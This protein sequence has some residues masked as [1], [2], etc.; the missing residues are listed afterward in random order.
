LSLDGGQ[1]LVTIDHISTQ[2]RVEPDGSTQH[3]AITFQAR[4]EPSA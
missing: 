2:Y 1:R 4:T 3:A